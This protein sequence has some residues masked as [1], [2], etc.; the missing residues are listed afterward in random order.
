MQLSA[1]SALCSIVAMAAPARMQAKTAD[2]NFASGFDAARFDIG[3]SG[4]A[5][6]H[7]MR[8]KISAKT[9][10]AMSR[11]SGGLRA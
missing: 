5:T 1:A 6:Q 4:D 7:F 10:V 8:R 11:N 9:W 2:T 3:N